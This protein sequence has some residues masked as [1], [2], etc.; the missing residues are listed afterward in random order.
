MNMNEAPTPNPI[1]G[2]ITETTDA[3]MME[4][5]SVTPE[6]QI[7]TEN[8][9]RPEK[10]RAIIA[11]ILTNALLRCKEKV[12]KTTYTK[13]ILIGSVGG[14]I[15]TAAIQ[16]VKLEKAT[17]EIHR[18]KVTETE[19]KTDVDGVTSKHKE[20]KH[21]DP[22]TTHIINALCGKE[23]FTE[24]EKLNIAI[25]ITVKSCKASKTPVPEDIQSWDLQEIKDLYLKTTNNPEY[26]LKE[27][28]TILSGAVY[29]EGLYSI[30]WEQEK[31]SGSPYVR[32]S[33]TE[34][35]ANIG[36]VHNG[37]FYEADTHTMYIKP[38]ALTCSNITDQ[39]V[40]EVSHALQYTEKP[41]R[42]L[43]RNICDNFTAL[44]IARQ[45]G[46]DTRDVRNLILY[47]EPGTVE[48]EAHKIIEP[49]LQAEVDKAR[50]I[51][52]QSATSYYPEEGE[53]EH[54][55]SSNDP[56]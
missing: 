15:A 1:E 16:G 4:E 6:D 37:A 26:H 36:D 18:D 45:T 25:G 51:S 49:V 55:N 44:V 43:L 48:Y 2:G 30:I 39:Y 22:E 38:E 46:M 53:S 13:S 52:Y 27:F 54:K 42:N 20:F 32:W 10:L 8:K 47:D 31:R 24:N 23:P 34:N 35:T 11:D 12:R 14:I 21:E 5:E 3:K 17:K 29:L 19:V 33:V 40:A 56:Y 7:D 41:V 50:N 28:D 9:S